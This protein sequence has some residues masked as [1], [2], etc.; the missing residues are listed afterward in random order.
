MTMIERV[1]RAM[2]AKLIADDDA[3]ALA[4]GDG[5]ENITLDGSFDL[6]VLA[7]AAIEAMR[8]PTEAM[9]GAPYDANVRILTEAGAEP[10]LDDA[11]REVWQAMID[12]ALQ[13]DRG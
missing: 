6:R 10:I 2:F 13:E 1:A 4:R 3:Y 7:R 9:A 12:A 11:A 8:E 5:P